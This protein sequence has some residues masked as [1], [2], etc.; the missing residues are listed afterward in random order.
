[1]GNENPPFI[2]C[3][4]DPVYRLPQTEQTKG[5][6]KTSIPD[7]LGYAFANIAALPPS[8]AT[9]ALQAAGLSEDRKGIGNR[10]EITPHASDTIYPV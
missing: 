7:V 2:N 4:V 5:T 8:T 10:V 9:A 3:Q 1:M 6:D